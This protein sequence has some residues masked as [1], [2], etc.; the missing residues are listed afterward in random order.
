MLA[1]LLAHPALI[2]DVD[3]AF[4]H[5][6][7]P[8]AEEELRQALHDFAIS[9]KRLDT[10]SLFTHLQGLGLAEAAEIVQAQAG[11]ELRLPPDAHTSEAAQSWWSLYSLMEFSIDMLRAQRDEAQARW[12]AQ[13]DDAAA[14]RRLIKY[15]ELLRAAQ[16]GEAGLES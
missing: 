10:A 9:A 12:L 8:P 3:E 6:L 2:H 13:P 11:A 5:V 7:L 1:I 4:A 14:L 15:N 16:T